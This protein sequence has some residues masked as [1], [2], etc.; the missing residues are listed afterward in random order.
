MIES[1]PGKD[2]DAYYENVI[3][4]YVNPG[5]IPELFSAQ[6]DVVTGDGDILQSWIYNKCELSSY[7][8]YLVDSLSI[9]KFQFDNTPEIR[10]QS[11]FE[12]NGFEFVPESQA[13][14][15]EPMVS[16]RF[17]DTLF[18][19]SNVPLDKE[20]RGMM[21]LVE[22]SDGEIPRPIITSTV[23]K[24]EDSSDLLNP[25]GIKQFMIEGLSGKDVNRFYK[26]AFERYVNPQKDPEPFDAR[27]SIVTGDG[28]VLQNWKYSKCGLTNFAPWIDDDLLTN[29]YTLTTYKEWRTT[30]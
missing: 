17:G 27:I 23:S 25:Q 10:G 16:K 13:S 8:P 4:R 19:T 1:L 12:C 20:Q 30:A 5:K 24:Y 22:F 28:T 29:K 21:F 15:S 11:I 7:T 9:I 14:F 6:V 18:Y 26:F 3:Q 2:K